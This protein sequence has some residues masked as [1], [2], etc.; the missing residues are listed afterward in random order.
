[1]ARLSNLKLAQDGATKFIYELSSTSWDGVFS[2]WTG[3]KLLVWV[4][5]GVNNWRLDVFPPFLLLFPLLIAFGFEWLPW[6][7]LYL[8]PVVWNS[9][10]SFC[11]PWEIGLFF[12]HESMS[13]RDMC[14]VLRNTL[15]FLSATHRLNLLTN[16]CTMKNELGL[17][18]ILILGVMSFLLAGRSDIGN[19]SQALISHLVC[20]WNFVSRGMLQIIYKRAIWSWMVTSIYSCLL[21]RLVM[22]N[23]VSSST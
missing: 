20:G 16:G 10:I 13:P 7:F 14:L 11:N 19:H 5:C 21:I 2:F 4:F 6:L 22:S 23:P 18:P 3:E 8:G 1:M 15:W 12:L 9:C 17:T